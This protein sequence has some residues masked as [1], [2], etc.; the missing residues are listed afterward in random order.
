MKRNQFTTQNIE[1]KRKLRFIFI[2]Q[3]NEVKSTS[4]AGHSVYAQ[5]VIDFCLEK[6]M[7]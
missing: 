5:V 4:Y 7:R 1:C 3:N 6:M 2:S